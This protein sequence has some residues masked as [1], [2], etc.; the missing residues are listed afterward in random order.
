MSWGGTANLP[1]TP[2]ESGVSVSLS[3]PEA[4]EGLM[5]GCVQGFPPPSSGSSSSSP[6]SSS[7]LSDPMPGSAVILAWLNN[8]LVS[9]TWKGLSQV[10]HKWQ[11]VRGRSTR[12]SRQEGARWGCAGQLTSRPLSAEQECPGLGLGVP[13]VLGH[14]AAGLS[15]SSADAAAALTSLLGCHSGLEGLS[16]DRDQTCHFIL[17]VM[18][19]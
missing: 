18:D 16:R 8:S 7:S 6:P 2:G 9:R 4:W 12:K 3:L 15:I 1:L 19:G 13:G 5:R 17:G 14:T 10:P 11:L